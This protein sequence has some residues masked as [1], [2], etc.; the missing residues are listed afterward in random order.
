[1]LYTSFN[2]FVDNQTAAYTI[3]TPDKII[4]VESQNTEIYSSAEKTCSINSGRLPL[5]T[6]ELKDVYSKWGAANSYERYKDKNTIA[7]WTQQTEEDKK[8]GWTST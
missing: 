1:L 5:S 3:N 2:S 6:N 8:A 4:S 7:A